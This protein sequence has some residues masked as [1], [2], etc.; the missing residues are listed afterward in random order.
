MEFKKIKFLF[1]PFQN[2]FLK[3]YFKMLLWVIFQGKNNNCSLFK[4]KLLS[5][6]DMCYV[7]L[8]IS[9]EVIKSVFTTIQNAGR[10][11]LWSA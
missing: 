1:F 9:L 3:D 11:G 4:Q 2:A 6:W 7:R 10:A 8:K 5:T